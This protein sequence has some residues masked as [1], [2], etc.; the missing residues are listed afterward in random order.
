MRD[1]CPITLVKQ[2]LCVGEISP[3]SAGLHFASDPEALQEI[4][5]RDEFE[6]GDRYS[7]GQE[8]IPTLL[9]S[10]QYTTWK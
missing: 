6:H 1:F 9:N 7:I 2:W 4:A 5:C 10:F 3:L 8:E